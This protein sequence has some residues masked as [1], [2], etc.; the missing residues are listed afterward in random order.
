MIWFYVVVIGICTGLAV[1]LGF[2]ATEM[3]Q[4]EKKKKSFY[5][6]TLGWYQHGLTDPGFCCIGEVKI[7]GSILK[8]TPYGSNLCSIMHLDC[9]SINPELR[10]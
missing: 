4:E 9:V 7:Q 1:Y 5:I 2:K 6:N 3:P 10:G 8:K